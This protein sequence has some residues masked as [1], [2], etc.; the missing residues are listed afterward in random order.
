MN[1]SRSDRERILAKVSHLVSR[2]HFNP[3]LNGA[4]WDELVAQQ[5]EEVLNATDAERFEQR[6]QK[7]VA[8]LRTSHT[9]FFHKSGRTVPARHAI[10][11]TLKACKIDG[12]ERWVFQDVHDGGAASIAKIN[13]GDILLGTN[14]ETIAPPVQPVFRMA[15]QAQ[16]T[17]EKPDGRILRVGVAIPNPLSRK[18]PIAQPHPLLVSKLKPNLGFIK[19]RIFPGA[20]GIDF[21]ADIDKAVKHIADCDRLIVDLRGNTGGGIGGLRL[22]SYLTPEKRPIGYSLTSGRAKRGYKKECLRRFGR[23]P[24]RK[25]ALLWLICRYGFGDHSICLMTEGLGPQQF[26]GRIVVLVNEHSASAAEMIAAFAKENRL[27]TIIG[28]KTAG[29]LLSGS[30]FHVGQGYMLALPVAAYHTWEGTLLEGSGVS[31]DIEVDLDCRKL[32]SGEDPQLQRAVEIA[33]NL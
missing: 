28:E 27:A 25:I 31:P 23:I 19:I 21:A 22:M 6:M 26:H 29:R 3:A 30:A 18:R 17:I 4:N 12:A 16:L 32:R 15:N 9:G 5:S 10:N 33:V 20:V 11:A 2:K 1:I 24:S 14:N 7:L 13:P 8:G